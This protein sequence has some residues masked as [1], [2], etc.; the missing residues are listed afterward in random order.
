MATRRNFPKGYAPNL[1]NIFAFACMRRM[2]NFAGKTL[3]EPLFAPVSVKRSNLSEPLVAE[4]NST[5]CGCHEWPFNAHGV[6]W[7]P[8]M[9]I[10]SGFFFNK[11]GSAASKSSMAFFFAAKLPSSPYLS[12]YLK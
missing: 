8:V 6:E 12:V 2:R 11:I 7:S 3:S 4:C 9:A 1:S 10:T 5:G